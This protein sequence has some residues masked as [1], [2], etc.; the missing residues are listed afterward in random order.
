[1]LVLFLFLGALAL[2]VTLL[3]FG[4][5]GC[6]LSDLGTGPA[7]DYPTT[8]KATACLVSYWRLGDSTPVPSATGAAKDQVG[9]NNGTYQTM[10]ASPADPIHYS[11]PAAG[12]ATT[13]ETPGILEN[14]KSDP[15]FDTEGGAGYVQVPFT[16]QLNP[17]QFTF[18]AWVQPDP[19]LP[20]D[21]NFYCLAES[22]G[23]PGF[24]GP[25]TG[26]GLYL[27]PSAP[28]NTDGPFW[29]VWMGSGPHLV[30]PAFNRVAI[31]NN[32]DPDALVGTILR[33]TYL[34]L[35]F[36]TDG[37]FNLWLYYP[38]TN[39][40]IDGCPNL[41]GAQVS[42]GTGFV[43]NNDPSQGGGGDFFIGT[44]SNLVPTATPLP[45]T[46]LY[47]FK[48]K[49]QEVALYNCSLVPAPAPAVPCALEK[50]IIHE[51]AGGNI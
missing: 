40:S 14:Y 12:V 9:A 39:Q 43:P 11:P 45:T 26:W 17:P 42:V 8:I 13:G 31:A 10:P 50:L 48:G 47:P 22:T 41:R 25:E 1:M 37:N 36:D 21:G 34:A 23:P 38:D 20:A 6:G 24:A 7:L 32:S 4:F 30:G 46:R 51:L 5:V 15:C 2:L 28:G 49:I 27:G 19:T 3:L 33:L 16:A 35:T 18:E 29:Q 44:G